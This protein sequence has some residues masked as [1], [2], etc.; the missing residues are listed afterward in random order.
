MSSF[1]RLLIASL[2]LIGIAAGGALAATLPKD[3]CALL[4]PAD[5]QILAPKDK[6]GDGVADASA[7]PLGTECRY[8]WG[9]RTKE[10][11]E[12]ELTVMVMD[13]S[14]AFH[15]LSAET[16]EQGVMLKAKTKD[17]GP[18]AAVIPGIGDAAVFTYEARSHNAMAEAYI[19]KK[20]AHV[21]VTYHGDS[22]ANKDKVIALLKLAADRL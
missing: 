6:I 4:K 11:G 8:T 18:D 22:L 12:S 13:A 5:V 1:R 10:W 15:G 17:A 19:H 21:A 7:L 3:P 20:D 16:I 14:K 2:L 9:P